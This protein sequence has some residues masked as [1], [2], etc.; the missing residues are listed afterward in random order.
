M[1]LKYVLL[2]IMSLLIVSCDDYESPD[3]YIDEEPGE[4][5][6]DQYDQVADE[7]QYWFPEMKGSADLLLNCVWIGN[8]A[9]NNMPN[10]GDPNLGLPAHLAAQSAVGIINSSLRDGTGNV[11]VWLQDE[12]RYNS[13]RYA[14]DYVK[15][16]SPKSIWDVT[17]P[18]TILLNEVKHYYTG[19]ILVD[20]VNNPES[21]VYAA[22]AAHV[23]KAFISDVRDEQMY[24]GAGYTKVIDATQKTTQDAWN[25]YKDKCNNKALVLMPVGTGQLRDFVI[26][27][28]LFM[29]NIVKD[30]NDPSKGNNLALFEEVLKWLEPNSPVLGW[31]QGLAGEDV[32]VKPISEHG[33]MMVPYDW[34]CNTTMTSLNYKERQSNILAKVTNPKFIDFESSKKK[35]VT[36]YLSDGD[37]VGW[38]TSSFERNTYFTHPD[39]SANSMTFSV[40]VSN[41]SMIMP[42]QLQ[43]LFQLQSGKCSVVEALGGGYYYCDLF[44]QKQ[45]K[46]SRSEALKKIAKNVASHMRQHRVKVLGL[47]A[48]DVLG[49]DAKDAYQAYISANDQLE[50]IIATGYAPYSAGGGEI[51]WFTNSKG[52]DIP[53]ITVKYAIWNYGEV[54]G[55][56]E[57]SP[58]YIAKRL[59]SETQDSPFSAVGIHAWSAFHDIGQSM[60]ESA[61]C[62]PGGTIQGPGAASLCTAKLSDDTQVVNV[63]ELIWRIRMHYRPEQTTEVLSQ[64]Y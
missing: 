42:S 36:Y 28:G 62:L 60:D 17:A 43:N 49:A 21:A 14:L 53:V 1:K 12:A 26:A 25:E 23:H 3:R 24:A 51:L 50:G 18:Q 27:N 16:L 34:V 22:V 35:F 64:F 48:W 59:N 61:E 11:G 37:N 20:V 46:I 5:Y 31:E 47:V 57:G 44:A 32:F 63:E 13:Y 9:L 10:H 4:L 29:M 58:T 30:Q 6:T 33:H 2:A 56:R 54:N 41:L 15:G 7:G 45:K 19:Y 40:P 52:I 8:E 39:A 55:Q 38:M